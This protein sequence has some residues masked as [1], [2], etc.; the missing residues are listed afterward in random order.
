[1]W[2]RNTE[3]RLFLKPH[4]VSDFPFGI[5]LSIGARDARVMIR[6]QTSGLE[7]SVRNRLGPLLS[8]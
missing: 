3:L 1:M 6:F 2:L 4:K 8:F 5:R 7:E